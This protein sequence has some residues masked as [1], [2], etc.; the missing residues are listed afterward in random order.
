MLSALKKADGRDSV[1]LRVFNPASTPTKVRV[2]QP[3]LI[4]AYRTD[5]REHRQEK[6]MVAD[7][8][9]AFSLGGRKIETVEGSISGAEL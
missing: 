4:E 7:R 1:V 9:V 3:S 6:L 2:H 5:L 8:A